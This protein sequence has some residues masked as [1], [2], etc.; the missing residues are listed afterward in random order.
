MQLGLHICQELPV[1][2]ASVRA[3]LFHQVPVHRR[4]LGVDGHDG[5]DFGQGVWDLGQIIFL[6]AQRCGHNA[7]LKEW[8]WIDQYLPQINGRV[9]SHGL[10]KPCQSGS[11]EAL[12]KACRD[13]FANLMKTF[14]TKP[15]VLPIAQANLGQIAIELGSQL[16]LSG[17][18]VRLRLRL[19][20]V[21]KILQEG[22]RRVSK[23]GGV[24]SCPTASHLW[25][26]HVEKV[27]LVIVIKHFVVNHGP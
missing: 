23:L 18:A 6:S 22:S 8:C 11:I 15:C 25:V 9:C 14:S 16:Q 10:P 3:E 20:L 4:N 12:G 1:L 19:G 17:L 5:A 7:L 26:G 27:T 2:L 21:H 24:T 13:C